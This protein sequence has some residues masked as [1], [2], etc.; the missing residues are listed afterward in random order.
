MGRI[1]KKQV[2]VY[3]KP[4]PQELFLGYYNANEVKVI[5]DLLLALNQSKLSI[6]EKERVLKCITLMVKRQAEEW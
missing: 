3:A 4:D 2:E 6:Y 5:G 1:T